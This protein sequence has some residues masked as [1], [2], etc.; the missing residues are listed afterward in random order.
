MPAS[1][2]YVVRVIYQVIGYL[3]FVGVGDGELVLSVVM[4]SIGHDILGI[5]AN[6][7]SFGDPCDCAEAYSSIV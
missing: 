5:L 2:E 1:V 6:D 4:H 7:C 3:I